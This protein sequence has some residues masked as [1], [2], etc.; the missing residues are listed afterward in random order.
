VAA[1][2]KQNEASQNLKIAGHV[3]KQVNLPK[4]WWLTGR[5]AGEFIQK[6]IG[7]GY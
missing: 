1:E 4:V 3:L 2:T 6:S 5:L 7:V